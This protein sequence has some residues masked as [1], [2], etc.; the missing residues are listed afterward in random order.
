MAEYLEGMGEHV[1]KTNNSLAK[2]NHK[3]KGEVYKAAERNILKQE[4]L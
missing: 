3:M 1:S 4:E 2:G